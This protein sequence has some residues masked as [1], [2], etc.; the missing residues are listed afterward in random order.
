V[1]EKERADERRDPEPGANE[2]GALHLALGR[3]SPG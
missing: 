3:S 2:K 1:S